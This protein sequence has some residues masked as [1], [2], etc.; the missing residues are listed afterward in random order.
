MTRLGLTVNETKTRL[1]RLPEENFDFLGYTIG[2]F[3]G[4]D[5]HLSSARARPGKPRR[6]LQRVHDATTPYKHAEAQNCGWPLSVGCSGDG[7]RTSTK[8]QLCRPT[9]SCVGMCNGVFN[10]GCR[11]EVD[12]RALDTAN[13]RTSIST[14]HSACMPCHCVALTCRARRLDDAG[15]SRMRAICAS[16][17]TSGDWKRSHGPGLRHR[18]TA[19]AA[20]Q[21]PLLGTY[22]YRAS[23][24][25]LS[26][27]RRIV[28]NVQNKAGLVRELLKL[29]LPQP[30][31]QP[32]GAAAVR[33]DRQFARLRGNA[34]VPMRSSQRRINST[35]NSAVQLG[36]ARER[37][38]RPGEAPGERGVGGPE[39]ER[40][41]AGRSLSPGAAASGRAG[42]ALPMLQGGGEVPC[43]AGSSGA[44]R[45]AA[46]A[47]SR[48]GRNGSPGPLSVRKAA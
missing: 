26:T 40:L 20:G 9:K 45:S 37:A 35:A 3:Y 41:A 44:M 32:V 11:D 4:R 6:L 21:R 43:P 24:R 8:G 38:D 48:S 16:G 18:Q 14:R 13:I 17:L 7:L 5:G 2:R 42:R 10:V 12:N 22:R 28:E 47:A 31:A 19:K 29:D 23:R 30:D 33:R 34:C 36:R 1:A 39:G 46:T 15:E 25:T 27:S